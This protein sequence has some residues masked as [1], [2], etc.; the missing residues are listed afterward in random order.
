MLQKSIT[1]II[2]IGKSYKKVADFPPFTLAVCYI[3]IPK[4]LC[5]YFTKVL[6]KH[7]KIPIAAEAQTTFFGLPMT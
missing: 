5:I 2:R 3:G 4:K 1:F 6:K 7:A